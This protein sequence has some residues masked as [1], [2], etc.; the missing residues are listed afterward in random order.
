MSQRTPAAYRVAE[1]I[2]EGLLYAMVVFSPWA[3][4]T[5]VDWAILTMNIAGYCMGAILVFK[6]VVCWRT[7][8][9][10]ATWEQGG[11]RWIAWCL[12]ALTLFL[13][14]WCWLSAWNYRAVFLLEFR[15]FEY[16]DNFIP[17][18]PHSYD[19]ASSWSAFRTYLAWACSFWAIRDWLMGKT[20]HERFS[21]GDADA[22]E[23]PSEASSREGRSNRGSMR[24]PD[25]LRR[26]L[27]VL[28]INGAVLATEGV[29]QRLTGT[30]KLLWLVEPRLM[31]KAVEQF[32]PFAYR[33]NAGQYLNLLW[34]VCLGF[35]WCLRSR[36]KASRRIGERAGSSPHVVLLPL[37]V[38]MIAGPLV[39]ASRGALAITLLL[40]ATM[41]LGFLFGNRMTWGVRFGVL[42]L[43][44][45]ALAG[46]LFVGW[47]DI[48]PR[49]EEF[50]WTGQTSGRE[51]I[52]ENA[53]AM[54]QEYGWQGSGP[55]TF[56]PLY[57]LYLTE[58]DQLWEWYAHNDWLETRITLGLTGSIAVWLGLVLLTPRWLIRSGLP[59]PSPLAA[60]L[61]LSMGGVL[62]HALGDFPFQVYS[63][64][65][66]FL[67]FAALASLQSRGGGGL[68][69]S[70]QG[71]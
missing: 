19:A 52:Y 10:P 40:L 25:R 7:G 39:S 1:G 9:E 61:L 41:A 24:I 26:L 21:L 3:F 18:L 69:D 64:V 37:A 27:W 67:I 28:C 58:G 55:G 46:G 65:F 20:R 17:W 22:G 33:G 49:V 60:C 30:S 31:H 66:L 45:V 63:I 57:Q 12:A 6:R 44:A 13:L 43:L 5:T 14:V 23:A 53:R 70:S 54:V 11:A 36:A 42:G 32:G 68:S 16:R 59:S 15:R 50:L 51:K 4:G 29:L 56:G 48:A 2:T 8:Y 71:E 35:W 47:K 38:V 62:L 34:P